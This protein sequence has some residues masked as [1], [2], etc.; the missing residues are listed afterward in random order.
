MSD[1]DDEQFTISKGSS[2]LSTEMEDLSGV[3]YRPRTHTTKS[4]YETLLSF[5][6]KMIGDQVQCIY[7]T[8]GI[9]LT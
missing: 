9:D 2:L 5:I 4:T 1:Q 7:S 8:T 3:Y 6:H